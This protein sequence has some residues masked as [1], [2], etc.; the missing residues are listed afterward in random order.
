MRITRK[1][2][3]PFGK[4]ELQ[5]KLDASLTDEKWNVS[6][7]VLFEIIDYAADYESM[8]IIR[9]NLN[10]IL[11]LS[12]KQYRRIFKVRHSTGTPPYRIH[13]QKRQHA[14]CQRNQNALYV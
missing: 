9:D 10:E 5:K 1:Q 6:N 8:K 11:A 3:I 2:K 7:T 12:P 13:S 14:D 4:T